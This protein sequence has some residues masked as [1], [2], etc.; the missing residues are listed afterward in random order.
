MNRTVTAIVD[1]IHAICVMVGD[2]GRQSLCT[3]PT[4]AADSRSA[5]P[6]PEALHRTDGGGNRA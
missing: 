5:A 6:T 2:R 3:A 4:S 1:R